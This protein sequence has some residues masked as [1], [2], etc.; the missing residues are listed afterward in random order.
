M[1]TKE[2][3]INLNFSLNWIVLNYQLFF[4]FFVFNLRFTPGH[5]LR[6]FFPYLLLWWTECV[7]CFPLPRCIPWGKSQYWHLGFAGIQNPTIL[8]I[9]TVYRMRDE[10]F[11]Q[12]IKLFLPINWR[13]HVLCSNASLSI[14]FKQMGYFHFCWCLKKQRSLITLSGPFAASPALYWAHTLSNL[15]Q[16]LF[17]HHR[18]SKMMLITLGDSQTVHDWW[19]ELHLLS[20]QFSCRCNLLIVLLSHLQSIGWAVMRHTLTDSRLSLISPSLTFADIH[21]CHLICSSLLLSPGFCTL[22]LHLNWEIIMQN[23]CAHLLMWQ[24]DIHKH[25]FTFAEDKSNLTFAQCI[26]DLNWGIVCNLK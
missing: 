14:F 16:H 4:L 25:T 18:W 15:G 7:V 19:H 3:Y 20:C 13:R 10:G 12:A 24:W 26:S 1:S 5:V 11:C 17:P 23:V 22:S 6:A 21:S 2:K 9:Y 8:D